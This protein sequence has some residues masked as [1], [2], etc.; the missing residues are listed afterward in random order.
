M[1]RKTIMTEKVSYSPALVDPLPKSS[2]RFNSTERLV[3]EVPP[4]ASINLLLTTVAVR[5]MGDLDLTEFWGNDDLQKLAREAD[6]DAERMA[7]SM[8][9][10]LS[11]VECAV[12]GTYDAERM[13]PQP[14]SMVTHS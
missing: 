3:R 14:L 13:S 2:S 6:F 8:L 5:T 1:I 10:E 9:E 7:S 12:N 4:S 11:D